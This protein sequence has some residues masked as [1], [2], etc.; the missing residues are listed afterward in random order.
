MTVN[1]NTTLDYSPPMLIQKSIPMTPF[2]KEKSLLN[3]SPLNHETA[4][5]LKQAKILLAG[6]VLNQK[7]ISLLFQSWNGQVHT[8]N[9]GVEVIEKIYFTQYDLILIDLQMLIMDGWET[10]KFIR[11]RL[12]QK[13]PL[14]AIS[15]SIHQIDEKT[16]TTTGFNGHLYKPIFPQALY[17]LIQILEIDTPSSPQNDTTMVSSSIDIQ[18]IKELA[19]N[20]NE[21]I[22]EIIYIF[23]EQTKELI[24]HI[25]I[26]QSTQQVSTLNAM[27][28][29]YKSS[30]NSVGNKG[31]HNLC[32]Q[33][34]KETRKENPQWAKINQ[35]CDTLLLECKKILV[36]VPTILA[37]LQ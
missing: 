13:M 37:E 14:I 16:L 35:H 29:K 11:T 31:L 18:F 27:V 12:R 30:A 8:A 1:R 25:P 26:L 3:L 24:E 9:N 36:E 28:H 33:M 23:E 7:K 17:N 22:R 32:G 19:G 20:D 34:E 21:F 10:A 5:D 15:S 6:N 2:E 4:L